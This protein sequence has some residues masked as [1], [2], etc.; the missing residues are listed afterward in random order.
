MGTY[1]I[2]HVT[3][4]PRAVKK[5]LFLATNIPKSIFPLSYIW[6]SIC[7]LQLYAY[8]SRLFSELLA[9]ELCK[10]CFPDYS[11]SCL[12][13]TFY[14]KGVTDGRFLKQ[15]EAR[16]MLILALK[17]SAVALVAGG[18]KSSGDQMAV[19]LLQQA[20][21]YWFSSSGEGSTLWK[22]QSLHAIGSIA[23]MIVIF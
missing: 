2:F 1:L 5:K 7:F 6:L 15:E 18:F 11:G 12:L 10:L 22:F 13:V 3:E 19:Y 4:Q 17:V 16:T 23:D 14:Q 9:M 21:T 20:N 8:S